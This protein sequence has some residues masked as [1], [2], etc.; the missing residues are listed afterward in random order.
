MPQ[1]TAEKYATLI[2]HLTV[3]ARHVTRDINPKDE[4]KNV[5]IRTK[6]NKELIIS[7]DKAFIV[8][9]IQAWVPYEPHS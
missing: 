5:R 2:R 7:H 3:K 6:T 8:I 1:E 9:V 4:L